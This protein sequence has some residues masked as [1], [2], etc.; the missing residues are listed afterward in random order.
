MENNN[1]ALRCSVPGVLIINGAS[2]EGKSH[3]IRYLCYI[4]RSILSL[5]IAFSDTAF[6][7]SNLPFLSAN[8]K[9][10]GYAPLKLQALMNLQHKHAHLPTHLRPVSFVIFDDCL[11]SHKQ[12]NCPI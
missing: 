8:K 1:L 2:Q 4:Y 6:R 3:F 7:A 5:G 12:W 10:Q 9:H 11:S